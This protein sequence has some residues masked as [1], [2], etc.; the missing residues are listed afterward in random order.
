MA[1]ARI[2]KAVRGASP[3]PPKRMLREAAEDWRWLAALEEGMKL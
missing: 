2:V 3:T 1:C